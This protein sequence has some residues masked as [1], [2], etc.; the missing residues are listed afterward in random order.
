MAVLLAVAARSKS[1]LGPVPG[2]SARPPSSSERQPPQEQPA[3]GMPFPASAFWGA[4]WGQAA[5]LASIPWYF[6]TGLT[7]TYQLLMFFCQRLRRHVFESWDVCMR[8]MLWTAHGG[9]YHETWQVFEAL[10]AS[11]LRCHVEEHHPII[12]MDVFGDHHPVLA[13][14]QN[15]IMLLLR[16]GRQGC[17]LTTCSTAAPVRQM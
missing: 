13:T 3:V 7:A 4:I 8:R 10:L 17:Y 5:P 14:I 1:P 2:P 6:I 15:I 9:F 11:T 12:T 16:E